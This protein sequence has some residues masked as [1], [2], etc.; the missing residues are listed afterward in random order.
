MFVHARVRVPSPPW[1]AGSRS[2]QL[3]SCDDAVMA[4]EKGRSQGNPKPLLNVVAVVAPTILLDHALRIAAAAGSTRCVAVE[5]PEELTYAP[6]VDG[7]LRAVTM[8]RAIAA[9]GWP[10]P[11][12]RY[13]AARF[14][15][16]LLLE[17]GDAHGA[18]EMART[19]A[20]MNVRRQD[21]WVIE[22][23]RTGRDPRSVPGHPRGPTGPGD[24]YG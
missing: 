14:G 13:R 12:V 11:D 20:R 2:R 23:A 4:D 15:T 1:Q 24:G 19:A 5:S 21:P 7:V 6:D 16:E 18:V 10:W 17:I 22:V 3:R 8:L 9:V